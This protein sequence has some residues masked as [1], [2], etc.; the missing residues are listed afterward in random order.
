MLN[1]LELINDILIEL[2]FI[3]DYRDY[4]L[5]QNEVYIECYK[6]DN[7]FIFIG[8][9]KKNNIVYGISK[10]LNMETELL[11]KDKYKDKIINIINTIIKELKG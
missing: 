9:F 2:S 10:R 5:I 6:E 1:S 8:K 4:Y 7:T 3:K 11:D